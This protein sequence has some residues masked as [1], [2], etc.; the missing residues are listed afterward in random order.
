MS[1]IAVDVGGT[2][3]AVALFETDGTLV[4]KTIDPVRSKKG[5]EIAE[6]IWHRIR[7]FIKK[8]EVAGDKAEAVGIS[9][10]GIYDKKKDTVWAPNLSGWESFPL[11]RQITENLK[12]QIPLTIESDRSCYI[13][14]EVWRGNARNCKDA[15]FLA[16]GTGIGAGI[17]VDGRILQGTGNIAGAVGWM[18]LNQPYLDEYKKFGCFE[19][20]ASG[21]GIVRMARKYLVE[22][23]SLQSILRKKDS[24]EL[25]T[26]AIFDAYEK[27]DPL[28][29][30]VIQESIEYWGMA[31]ANLVSI[32]NPEKILFGG[33]VFE[34]A[35][36]LLGEIRSETEKWA[37]PIAMKQ[38]S[39]EL[40]KL[41]SEAGIYGAAYL[42]LHS[43]WS[44]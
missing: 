22:Q 43:L 42:A 23:S 25:D 36:Q 40:A 34:T 19:Y 38:V 14:G 20:H 33:G 35:A 41:G 11:K 16:V 10:P 15:I 28:A 7:V 17:F 4:E 32:F 39:V 12:R 30:K 37:Q 6:I 8:A 13:L 24:E 21:E 27:D 44:K 3:I 2:K 29:K 26:R 5:D 9:I 18:G 31:A 1:L